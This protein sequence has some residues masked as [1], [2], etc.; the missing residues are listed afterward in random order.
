MNAIKPN[1][2]FNNMPSLQ[3]NDIEADKKGATE[4]EKAIY[5]MTQTKGWLITKEY[6]D[7]LYKDLNQVNKVAIESGASLEE[8]GRNTVVVSLTQDILDKLLN[9]VSDAVDACTQNEQ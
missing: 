9:R 1:F 3:I 4:E 7:N 6:I 8:I 5:A 2:F